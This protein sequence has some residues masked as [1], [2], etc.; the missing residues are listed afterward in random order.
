M[1]FIELAYQLSSE[2][3][4]PL[5]D[6][7]CPLPS[8]FWLLLRSQSGLDSLYRYHHHLSYHRRIFRMTPLPFIRSSLRM[9]VSPIVMSS[10]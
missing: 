8:S 6:G 4:K 9:I 7:S 3:E 10:G 2:N 1:S 5:L